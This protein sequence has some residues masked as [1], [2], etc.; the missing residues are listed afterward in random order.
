MRSYCIFIFLLENCFQPTPVANGSIS[1]TEMLSDP[2]AY[3]YNVSVHG[4]R[5][6]S[7]IT[8]E[9][10]PEYI[11]SGPDTVTCQ[12]NGTWSSGPT[13]TVFDGNIHICP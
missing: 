10:D 3:K 11:L 5:I 9:C 4:Y 8:F 12:T 6:S 13:C 7:N 2:Y 1:S